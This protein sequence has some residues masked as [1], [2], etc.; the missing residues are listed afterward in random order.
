MKQNGYE[1]PA[2]IRKAT[3]VAFMP[4]IDNKSPEIIQGGLKRSYFLFCFKVLK[5]SKFVKSI[6]EVLKDFKFCS[7]NSCFSWSRFKDCL[8]VEG[9]RFLFYAKIIVS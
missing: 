2:K 3:L 5:M 8:H 1:S 6:L 7:K 9:V 4:K